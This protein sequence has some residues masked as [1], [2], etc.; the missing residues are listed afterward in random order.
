MR[1]QPKGGGIQICENDLLVEA[2]HWDQ[3]C[4]LLNYGQLHEKLFFETSGEFFGV[5]DRIKPTIKEGREK[6]GRER[7]SNKLLYAHIEKAAIRFESWAE[8]H[9]PGLVAAMRQMSQ[10]MRSQMKKVA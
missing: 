8:N 9:S 1:P 2:S 3:A 6:E 10:Q 7:F 5:W 4:A